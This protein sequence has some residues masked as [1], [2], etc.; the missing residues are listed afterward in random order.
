MEGHS[1]LDDLGF[2]GE[3]DRK[4]ELA[5]G[6]C[7]DLRKLSSLSPPVMSLNSLVFP[8]YRTNQLD[9]SIAF[10]DYCSL[11][12]GRVRERDKKHSPFFFF[13]D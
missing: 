2:D 12:G 6:G 5:Y 11:A 1:Q 7:V 3:E 9:T 4:V 13:Y 8:F 10:S